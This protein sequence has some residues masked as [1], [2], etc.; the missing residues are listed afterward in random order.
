MYRNLFLVVIL[1][2]IISVGCTQ[3]DKEHLH[4]KIIGT[5]DVHGSVFSYDFIEGEKS[6]GSLAALSGFLA[7]TRKDDDTEVLLLDNGDLLQGDPSVYYYNYIDTT[8]RHLISEVLNFL[9]YDA[10]TVG[11][12]DIEPGHAV[13]DKLREDFNFPWMAANAIDKRTGEPYFEPYTVVEKG[14]LKIAVLGLITPSIPQWL[15]ERVY[16]NIEFEDMVTSAGRWVRT[17]EKRVNPDL[18]IGLFHT[19]QGETTHVEKQ[20]NAAYAIGREVN[21]LDYIF[22]GHDHNRNVKTIH[23]KHGKQVT[24]INAGPDASYAAS[25]DLDLMKA[26]E[27]L[28]IANQEVSF[29]DLSNYKPTGSFKQKFTKYTADIQAYVDKKV[30]FLTEPISSRAALFGPSKW[31]QLI[32]ETQ[33]FY[34]DADLSLA[35][36]LSMNETLHRGTLTVG[37]LFKLY[38]FRNLLYTIE[39]TGKEIDQYLEYS[40]NGWFT[41]MESSDDHLLKFQLD[42][43]GHPVYSEDYGYPLLEGTFYNFDSGYGLDYTVDV[44]QPGGQRV[45]IY[46]VSGNREFNPDQTYRVAMNSYRANGGGGHLTEG[47]GLTKKQIDRRIQRIEE[48]DVRFLIRRYISQDDSL[49]INLHRNWQ[50]KPAE[51]WKNSK[52]VD[53]LLL[54]E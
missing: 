9:K 43:I 39:L 13:Y 37:D 10:A 52:S 18:M 26:G 1:L 5:T 36:P 48:Q 20:E 45:F 34:T 2:L 27:K 19:G 46:A 51:W 4:L 22:Y 41:T 40:Y 29:V 17:I 24:L 49:I 38:R 44:S 28:R 35:A 15:P 53:S 23:N 50:V 6:Y 54:F 14:G 21:G 12:H 7:E 33:L 31:M 42:S 25:L 47:A 3:P 30:T 8:S 16:S 32:H 11:N